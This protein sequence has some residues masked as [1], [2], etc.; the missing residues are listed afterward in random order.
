MKRDVEMKG[1]SGIGIIYLVGKLE[2]SC[3]GKIKV[4][5]YVVFF[6]RDGF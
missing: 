4:L 3:R 5:R 1:I 6:Y 2:I